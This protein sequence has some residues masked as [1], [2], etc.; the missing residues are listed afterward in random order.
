MECYLEYQRNWETRKG[1]GLMP[2]HSSGEAERLV[3]SKSALGYTQPLA[4]LVIRRP[5]PPGPPA[6]QN[7]HRDSSFQGQS[8]YVYEDD[9]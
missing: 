1:K 3:T 6:G 5:E 2:V 8:S 9:L 4:E 7:G